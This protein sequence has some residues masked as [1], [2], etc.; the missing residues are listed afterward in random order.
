[1]GCGLPSIL[2]SNNTIQQM[3]VSEN[4]GT[5]QSSILMG[6]SIVNRLFWDTSMYMETP[7]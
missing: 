6:F 2:H 3:E 5:P 7:R 1:M 4:R